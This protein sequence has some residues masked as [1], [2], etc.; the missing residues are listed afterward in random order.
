MIIGS[1]GLIWLKLKSDEVPTG[2]GVLSMDYMFLVMLCLV[3]VSGV[4]TLALRTTPAMGSIL[5]IHLGLV[6]SLFVTA[7]YG[8]FVHLVYRFLAIVKYRVERSV[9]G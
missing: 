6:A 9:A 8:K 1:L 5:V 2:A 3:S 4:L 7:P